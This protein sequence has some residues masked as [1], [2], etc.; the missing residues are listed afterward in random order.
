MT[1]VADAELS[2]QLDAQW[3]TELQKKISDLCGRARYWHRKYWQTRKQ[4]IGSGRYSDVR[5]DVGMYAGYS[6]GY[7]SAARELK[8]LLR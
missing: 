4:T 7:M 8:G 6:D 3:R 1:R 5:F 2:L